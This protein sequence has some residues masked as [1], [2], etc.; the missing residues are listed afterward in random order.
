DLGSGILP[1]SSNTVS[2]FYSAPATSVITISLTV[3]TGAPAF[4]TASTSDNFT[5]YVYNGDFIASDSIV[6]RGETLTFSITPDSKGLGAWLWSYGDATSS[7]T[8]TPPASSI[9]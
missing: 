2:L 5:I 4:C 6:C 8:L 9:T 7:A 1:N 3:N